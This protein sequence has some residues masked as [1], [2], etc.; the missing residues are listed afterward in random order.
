MLTCGIDIGSNTIEALIWDS[1]SA[2]V[3]AYDIARTGISPGGSGRDSFERALERAGL[4]EKDLSCVAATGYGRSV[5]LFANDT[6]TEIT[7]QA[8]GV[9]HLFPEARTVFDVGGQDSKI[10]AL[11]E[12]GSVLDFVMNDRCAAGTGRFLEVIAE[13]MGLDVEA[14]GGTSLKS[15]NLIRIAATCVVFAESEVVSLLSRGAKCEDVLAGIQRSIAERLVS[16]AGKVPL[17]AP[18]IFTG[19]VAKNPG[20]TKYLSEALREE[21]LVPEEPQITCALGASLLAAE[22][23]R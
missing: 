19:G 5:A 16:L 17:V 1:R 7:C 12:T 20:T 14:A 6:I 8:R 23:T 4:K 3:L 18:I 21:L 15:K 9:R 22:R 13:A 2:Q 10:I 11:D